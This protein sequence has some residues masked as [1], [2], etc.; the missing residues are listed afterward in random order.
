MFTNLITKEIYNELTITKFGE[1]EITN[2]TLIQRFL[3]F[4]QLFIKSISSA[5]YSHDTFSQM[6]YPAYA[7]NNYFKFSDSLV[8]FNKLISINEELHS[9]H[10]CKLCIQDK[11]ILNMFFGIVKH[12]HADQDSRRICLKFTDTFFYSNRQIESIIRN[13]QFLFQLLKRYKNRSNTKKNYNQFY[14]S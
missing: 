3:D 12:C 4:I 10:L 9:K 1:H 14:F 2:N 11:E 7:T 8:N 6:K 13:D 5:F